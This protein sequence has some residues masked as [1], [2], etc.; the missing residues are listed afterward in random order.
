MNRKRNNQVLIGIA[1]AASLLAGSAANADT[2][3]DFNFDYSDPSQGNLTASGTLVVNLT[4][5]QVL[6]G[7]GTIN[8]C[9]RG[10]KTA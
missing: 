9:G 7:T 3:Q 10:F 5:G 1:V 8:S 4:T 2:I 6:S